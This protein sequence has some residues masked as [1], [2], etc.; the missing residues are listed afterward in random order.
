VSNPKIGIGIVSWISEES[1][2]PELERCLDSLTSFYPV[3]IINGKWDDVKGDNP[4]SVLEAIDLM[5]SY[6]NVMWFDS[7]NQPEFINRN[8]YLIQATKM[9]CNYL[10]WVD[11]DEWVELP[12]GYEFLCNSIKKRF[13]KQPDCYTFLVHYFDKRMGGCCYKRRGIRYPT[14]TRHRNKH[15]ELWFVDKEVLRYPA[16]APNGLIIHQDK[17]FR[18]HKREEKMKIRNESNPIH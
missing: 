6:S 10:I 2:V 11:T 13:E 15:N 4:R 16:K 5:E 1:Q 7:P 9:D 3:I 12:C 17:I 8:E 14:F 18:T